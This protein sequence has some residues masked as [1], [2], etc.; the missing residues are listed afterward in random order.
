MCDLLGLLTPTSSMLSLGPPCSQADMLLSWLTRARAKVQIHTNVYL[1]FL[2]VIV[3]QLKKGRFRVRYVW[4]LF[5][6]LER[7]LRERNPWT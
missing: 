1:L 6:K 5:N 4:T 3:S 2:G 7:I